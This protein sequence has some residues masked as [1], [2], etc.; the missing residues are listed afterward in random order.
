L[1]I[2]IIPMTTK[3]SAVCIQAIYW[4][5]KTYNPGD[6]IEINKDDAYILYNAGV[7]GRIKNI[8]QVEFAVKEAPENR[9]K[10]YKRKPTV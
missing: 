2:G 3:R 1:A 4:K 5:G 8:Q 6:P 9:K 10:P 7:I